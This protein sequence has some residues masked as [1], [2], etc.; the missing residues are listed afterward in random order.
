MSGQ[1]GRIR[2]ALNGY[3]VNGKRVADAVASADAEGLRLPGVEIVMI[4]ADHRFA[5]SNPALV[6]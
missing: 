2:V 5:L 6:R 3:G 1:P 4:A